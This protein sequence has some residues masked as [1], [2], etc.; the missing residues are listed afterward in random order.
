MNLIDILHA[1]ADGQR[2]QV[3]HDA[4]AALEDGAVTGAETAVKD[5]ENDQ[6]VSTQP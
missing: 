1:L 3:L 5:L 6:Q 2:G 4:I